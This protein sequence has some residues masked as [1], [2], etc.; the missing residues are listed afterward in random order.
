[1]RVTHFCTQAGG[2]QSTP[3]HRDLLQDQTQA[4]ST[5]TSG[6]SCGGIATSSS[7]AGAAHAGIMA[8]DSLRTEPGCKAPT[9]SGSSLPL[10]LPALG[11]SPEQV[12]GNNSAEPLLAAAA[13]GRAVA[14]PV[15][16]HSVARGVSGTAAAAPAAHGPPTRGARQRVSAAATGAAAVNPTG[17]YSRKP[18]VP[19]ATRPAPP[20]SAPPRSRAV[21]QTSNSAAAAKC[22]LEGTAVSAG[23]VRGSGS[24]A[25]TL[26]TAAAGRQQKQN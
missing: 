11:V 12:D 19:V 10:E 1:M 17:H 13:A 4:S 23:P 21:R 8:A 26:I 24:A 22:G 14:P 25:A 3:P 9:I 2:V 20:T 7:S 6:N 15:R 5:S 16:N 18:P